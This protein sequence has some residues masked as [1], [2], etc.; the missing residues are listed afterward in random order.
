MNC[1]YYVFQ[2][3]KC[4]IRPVS[5]NHLLM[6]VTPGIKLNRPYC[7]PKPDSPDKE[8]NG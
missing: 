3:S 2:A 6:P 5:V 4:A 8:D 1:G 7:V